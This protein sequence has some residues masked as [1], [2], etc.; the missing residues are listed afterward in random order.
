MKRSEIAMII[1]IAS[2]SMMITFALAQSLLGDKVKRTA[3]VERAVTVTEDVTK[4]SKRIFNSTAINPTIEVCVEKS[5]D[6]QT[7][8]SDCSSPETTSDSPEAENELSP[9]A[10]PTNNTN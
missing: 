9:E 1:L 7:A 5:T 10:E 2:F 6:D 8:S 4:P 3:K